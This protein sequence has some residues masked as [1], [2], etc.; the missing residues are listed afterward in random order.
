MTLTFSD[1]LPGTLRPD[2]QILA[3]L[4]ERQPLLTKFK[5][6]LDSIIQS[7][8]APSMATI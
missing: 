8:G 2:P 6:S 4:F 3:D 1:N 7:L 5:C